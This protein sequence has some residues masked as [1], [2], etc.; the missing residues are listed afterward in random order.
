MTGLVVVLLAA[1]CVAVLGW[2]V[3][4]LRAD[5]RRP[6]VV[7]AVARVR[8]PVPPPVGPDRPLVNPRFAA[9]IA[10]ESARFA[11]AHR[12]GRLAGPV[13]VGVDV[14]AGGGGTVVAG[15]RGADRRVSVVWTGTPS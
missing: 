6:V 13:E 12:V 11:A 2:I 5:A 7:R 15:R 9:H 1:V 8:R 14:C 3:V 4:L 10:A